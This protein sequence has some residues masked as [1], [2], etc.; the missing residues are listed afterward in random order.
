MSSL[1]FS[2]GEVDQ[3]KHVSCKPEAVTKLFDK[4]TNIDNQHVICLGKAQVEECDRGQQHA[5]GHWPEPFL[6]A[7][8]SGYQ[9]TDYA[10]QRQPDYPYS[11]VYKTDLSGCQSEPS[12]V[13]RVKQEGVDK[14][15]QLSLRETECQ[16]EEKCG[17]HLWFPEEGGKSDSELLQYI[18]GLQVFMRPVSVRFRENDPVIETQNKE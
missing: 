18:G 8:H 10:A 5:Q 4:D 15:K 12:L 13:D 9:T 17:A 7:S 1:V 2:Y 11:A 16:H 6:Q 14:L 3:V